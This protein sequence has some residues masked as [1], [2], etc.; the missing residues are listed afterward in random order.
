M[1][2]QMS[3]SL[4]INHDLKIVF[5]IFSGVLT[6][7]ALLAQCSETSALPITSEYRELVDL[8]RVTAITATGHTIR[9]VASRPSPFSK[10]LPRI[11]LVGGPEQYGMGRMAQTYAE[12]CDSA[13][14]VVVTSKIAAAQLLG[15][16]LN[17]IP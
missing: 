5:S 7:Q 13:P 9:T 8:T 10:A 14:F 4:T 6:D 11:I 1:T 15:V 16:D 17:V 2:K 3:R 12:L